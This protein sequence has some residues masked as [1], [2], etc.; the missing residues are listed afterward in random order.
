MCKYSNLEAMKLK[1]SSGKLRLLLL[2]DII[3]NYTDDEHPLSAKELV[4]MLDDKGIVSERKSIYDDIQ[5]LIQYGMDINKTTIPKKGYFLAKRT[6]EVPE[7]QFFID[8]IKSS[9]SLTQ[10]KSK[11]LMLKFHSTISVY[12]YQEIFNEINIHNAIKSMNEEIYYNIYIINKAI[13]EN[14]IIS[15]NYIKYD[16]LNYKI[17]LNKMHINSIKPFKLIINNGKYYLI[18]KQVGSVDL[19]KYK[20]DKIKSINIIVD[21]YTKKFRKTVSKPSL[22]NTNK[23]DLCLILNKSFIDEFVDYFGEEI[24]V[25]VYKDKYL[26]C[27]INTFYNM[28]IENWI[29]TNSDYVYI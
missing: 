28:N 4:N 20:V 24:K 21:E 3:K 11:S 22:L 10:K 19:I 2:M 17:K 15:F 1:R 14:K 9:F 6:F 26:K 13:K 7:I 27:N 18:G 16:F 29:L 12:Q 23:I 8:S 5:T 25:V